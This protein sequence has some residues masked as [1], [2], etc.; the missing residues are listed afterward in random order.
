MTN[1]IDQFFNLLE[2]QRVPIHLSE[3]Y[4]PKVKQ[5]MKKQ[6]EIFINSSNKIKEDYFLSVLFKIYNLS[7]DWQLLDYMLADSDGNFSSMYSTQIKEMSEHIEIFGH[8]NQEVELINLF[9]KKYKGYIKM[10]YNL[11]NEFKRK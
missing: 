7:Y 9:I 1:E 2:I 10:R 4:L 6:Y 5:K 8:L 11:S 3:N